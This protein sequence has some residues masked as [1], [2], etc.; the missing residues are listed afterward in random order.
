MKNY[1]IESMSSYMEKLEEARNSGEELFIII[2]ADRRYDDLT[3]REYEMF[4]RKYGTFTTQEDCWNKID[5]L[6]PDRWDAFIPVRLSES[7][8]EARNPENDEVNA[9][10]KKH[11]GK[12]SH[13][14]KKEQEILDKY[15]ISRDEYGRFKG[16][17]GEVLAK[18]STTVYGP[19]K[20]SRYG[21]IRRNW[22][23]SKGYNNPNYQKTADSFD[24]VDFANYLNKD[25]GDTTSI[26]RTI[27]D[28]RRKDRWRDDYAFTQAEKDAL[29]PYSDEYKALKDSADYE[30]NWLDYNKNEYSYDS[31]EDIEKKV[32]EY[33]Q[34]LLRDRDHNKQRMDSIQADYDKASKELNDFRDSIKAKQAAKKKNE[35]LSLNE[36]D[37]VEKVKTNKIR[38]TFLSLSNDPYAP[39]PFYWDFKEDPLV[40]KV[41]NLLR[42]K[43]FT[44][45]DDVRNW[46]ELVVDDLT[47]KEMLTIYAGGRKIKKIKDYYLLLDESLSLKE[48]AQ[49]T[50]FMMKIL[51]SVQEHIDSNYSNINITIDPQATGLVVSDGNHTENY[52]ITLKMAPVYFISNG[53]AGPIYKFTPVSVSSV[54]DANQVIDDLIRVIEHDFDL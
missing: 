29:K 4:A 2:P 33:K 39:T 51:Q 10:I 53:L 47:D 30:K 22:D 43:G 21:T 8:T 41:C 49:H 6:A 52:N 20:A 23:L 9:I 27:Y 25:H 32:A 3:S 40:K 11:L 14:S 13:I 45:G 24:N 50:N 7:L 5:E 34:K 18:S 38:D 12:K 15:G 26:D 48:G 54:S 28:S 42:K 19:R 31:D 44:D 16:K 36:G 1:L 46:P 37:D 17:N 35:S